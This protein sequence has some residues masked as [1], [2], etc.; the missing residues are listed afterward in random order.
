MNVILL[1]IKETVAMP[2]V[3]CDYLVVAVV[4]EAG[5]DEFEAVVGAS[6]FVLVALEVLS[7]CTFPCCAD[8]GD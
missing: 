7:L 6:Y 1:D 4:A 2:A 3:D 5:L 8:F